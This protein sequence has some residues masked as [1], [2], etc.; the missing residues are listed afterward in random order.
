MAA[1][2]KTGG[3]SRKGIPN[4]HPTAFRDQLRTYCASIGADPFRFMADL[5]VNT[6]TVLVGVTDAGE[7][8]SQPAVSLGLKFQCAKEL[9]RYLEPQL[10][11]VELTGDPERP[12][13][14]DTAVTLRQALALAYGP[15][16][17]NGHAPS[18]ADTCR[19]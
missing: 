4:K 14:I 15:E 2:R 10:R 17:H 8:L 19:P 16:S 9:A 5:L 13:R 18:L 12:L 11:S 3:G 1:G 7:P 6:E